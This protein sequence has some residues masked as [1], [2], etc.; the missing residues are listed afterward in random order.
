MNLF[1]HGVPFKNFIFGSTASLTIVQIAIG[2]NSL[3][4][5]GWRGYFFPDRKNRWQTVCSGIF[6]GGT[7]NKFISPFRI[8]SPQ[9]MEKIFTGNYL[10]L[11][12]LGKMENNIG[13]GIACFGI[14]CDIEHVL[15]IDNEPKNTDHIRIQFD[16]FQ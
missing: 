10:I 12:G 7:E 15:F 16:K 5:C 8:I 6:A 2:N 14:F 11:R 1:L 9:G 3:W 13:V 4:A